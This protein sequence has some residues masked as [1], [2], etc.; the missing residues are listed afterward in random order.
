MKVRMF[1][2]AAILMTFVM[3]LPDANAQQKRST[4]DRRQHPG[5]GFWSNQAASRRVGHA[6]DYS[7]GLS[8]YAQQAESVQPDFA[9]THVDEIGRNISVAERI[10]TEEL[11]VAEKNEDKETIAD[12]KKII[13]NLKEAKTAHE[14]CR[15]HCEKDDVDTAKLSHSVSQVTKSLESAQKTQKEMM[16]RQHPATSK[17]SE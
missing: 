11:K 16:K 2:I 17:K 14:H 6:L 10:V 5:Q 15:E 12:L 13:H 1:C 7:R 9:Q 8:S 3:G 4:A